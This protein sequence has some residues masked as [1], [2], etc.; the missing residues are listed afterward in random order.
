MATY[1][2][3]GGQFAH[4]KAKAPSP[5]NQPRHSMGTNGSAAS[6]GGGGLTP[7]SNFAKAAPPQRLAPPTQQGAGA[8]LQQLRQQ[9]YGTTGKANYGAT[10]P[11][12]RQPGQVQPRGGH[13]NAQGQHIPCASKDCTP[14]NSQVPVYFC[15]LENGRNYCYVCW[16]PIKTRHPNKVGIALS[17][18]ELEAIGVTSFGKVPR[19]ATLDD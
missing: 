10:N 16:E 1:G 4:T 12:A 19:L 8:N 3:Q 14:E 2:K 9:S 13:Y 11:K 15:D 7:L 18:E 6:A 17:L 5:S